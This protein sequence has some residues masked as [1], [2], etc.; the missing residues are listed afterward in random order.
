MRILLYLAIL[1]GIPAGFSGCRKSAPP[2]APPVVAKPPPQG[3]KEAPLVGQQPTPQPDPVNQPAQVP[4][5]PPPAVLPSPA[6]QAAILAPVSVA[7]E[8]FQKVKNKVPNNL[9]EVVA[10]GF[11][12]NLPPVPVGTKIYYDPITVTVSIVPAR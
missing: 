5:A 12:K 1:S 3:T 2:V 10:A 4:V 11:L 7:L 6:E 9:N 8:S